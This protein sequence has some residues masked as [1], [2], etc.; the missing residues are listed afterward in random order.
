M[1]LSARRAYDRAMTLRSSITLLVMATCIAGC[2]SA[3]KTPGGQPPVLVAGDQVVEDYDEDRVICQRRHT[4][5]SHIPVRVCM[6][7]SE[8]RAERDE[9]QQTIGPLRPITGDTRNLDI[10]T[11]PNH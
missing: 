10:Q 5:G 11:V 2:S 1:L 7:E 9:L 8:M 6:T 4:A 3:G